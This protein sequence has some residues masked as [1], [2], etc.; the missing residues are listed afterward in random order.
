MPPGQ[1]YLLLLFFS[2]FLLFP[3]L[4]QQQPGAG[5]NYLTEDS[6]ALADMIRYVGHDSNIHLKPLKSDVILVTGV[7]VSTTPMF[8]ACWQRLGA[9]FYLC[10]QTLL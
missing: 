1:W 8:L 6:K 2:P 3:F 4:S 9:G 10:T 7:G 5:M